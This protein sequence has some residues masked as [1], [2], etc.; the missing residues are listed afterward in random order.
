MPLLKKKPILTPRKSS[1]L[2]FKGKRLVLGLDDDFSSHTTHEPQPNAPPSPKLATPP[3]HHKPSPPPL[4]IPSTPTPTTT[5]PAS[6]LPRT[7]PRLGFVG[8]SNPS[9]V[10][11]A[12]LDPVF[13]KLQDLRSQFY[14]FEDE[15]RITF[16]SITN[17]LTQMEARLG[18]KLDIVEVHTE[19]VDEEEPS[20]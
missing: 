17:Q 2:A 10:P 20:S 12:I 19:F 11:V 9:L 18:A 14:F 4:P 16:A 13:N 6:P 8:F 7:S 5:T 3:T 15:V 1:G